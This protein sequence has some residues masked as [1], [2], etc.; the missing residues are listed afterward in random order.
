M[1]IWENEKMRIKRLQILSLMVVM[2][3]IIVGC[4]NQQNDVRQEGQEQ[5]L[6][7]GV[8]ATLSGGAAVHGT[9]VV[10]G[11]KEAA[12]E[13]HEQGIEVTLIVEDNKNN[14]KEAVN[15]FHAIMS[16]NPDVI[17]T[18]MSGAS[19][20]IIPLAK[21]KGI[22]VVTSL[23]YA[24]FQ[25]YEN[26]FQYFQT[27]E[28][29]AKIAIDFF[30][31]QEVGSV[32]LLALDIEA[33]HALMDIV[34]PAFV[35]EGIE[36]V[37]LEYFDGAA[38]D[39]RTQILK[40]VE[41]KPEA[42]YVFDLRPD[43]IIGQINEQYEGMVVFTDTPVAT[44]QHKIIAELDGVYIAAQEYMIPR[45][46]ENKRF[47]DLFSAVDGNAEAG[48]GYDVVH[49]IGEAYVTGGN[50]VKEF[51]ASIQALQSYEGL[52][53]KVDVGESRKPSIPIRMVQIKDKTLVE[54]EK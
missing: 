43:R 17:F 21:E 1:H 11:A 31:N 48:M 25:N 14:P 23:T 53:G 20:A 45:T 38:I 41:K 18:T 22:P 12:K 29:L 4:T 34:E 49:L 32:G 33:G 30:V 2:A 44:N 10:I 3:L 16:Q 13:L 24:D 36:V 42:I 46:V 27:T 8:L 52:A 39:A 54:I 19:A 15:A 51:P 50:S 28:D 35:K 5:E 9:H 47:D 6:R 40:L 7:I 26:V 37:G